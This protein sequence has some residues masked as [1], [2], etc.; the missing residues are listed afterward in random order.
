MTFK[1]MVKNLFTF[2]LKKKYNIYIKTKRSETNGVE[3]VVRVCTWA[4]VP[5]T[6]TMDPLVFYIFTVWTWLELRQRK[7]LDK[8]KHVSVVF[9]MILYNNLD[10]NISYIYLHDL[11][12]IQTPREVGRHK[13]CTTGWSWSRDLIKRLQSWLQI[14]EE[15]ELKEAA[16]DSFSSVSSVVNSA[17]KWTV[18]VRSVSPPHSCGIWRCWLD[19]VNTAQVM[20][21]SAEQECEKVLVLNPQMEPAPSERAALR[22]SVELKSLKC[23]GEHSIWGLTLLLWH[24]QSVWSNQHL[25]MP[26]PWGETLRSW[27]RSKHKRVNFVWSCLR[28]EP[29]V[30]L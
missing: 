17:P 2:S 19:V 4:G 21:S 14:F 8:V 13:T 15:T 26:H 11:H 27:K 24:I 7:R 22:P 28:L 25:P 16:G 29:L 1:K 5:K 6:C 23:S 3:A 18:S 20:L 10:T 12:Y 30:S 9:D